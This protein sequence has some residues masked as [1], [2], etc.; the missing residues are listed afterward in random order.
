MESNPNIA[1]GA[2]DSSTAPRVRLGVWARRLIVA[3]SA[4]TALIWIVFWALDEGPNPPTSTNKAPLEVR[5]LRSLL[6]RDS[7][8]KPLWQ[9]AAAS[10][11]L[12]PDSG[13]TT[14]RQ[15]SRGVLFRDGAQFLT[16]SARLVRVAASRDLDASGGVNANGPDGFS[17]QTARARWWNRA[18]RVDCPEAVAATLRGL[19]FRAPQLRYEWDKGQLSCPKPVEVKGQGVTLRGN[20]M[21]VKVK[22]RVVKLSGGFEMVIDP[23]AADSKELRELVAR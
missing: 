3:L 12:A 14:L 10:V 17:F 1:R 19:Q 6:V 23:R 2:V 13:V 16:M 8:G 4:G 5:D 21:N 20:R 15:V 7:N 18:K 22:E 11:Q 9:I